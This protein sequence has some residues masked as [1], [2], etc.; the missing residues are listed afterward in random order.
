MP[1]FKI[2]DA[3][4]HYY[5][6]EDCF[7]RFASERM[8]S[9]KFVRW[10]TEADGKRKRLFVGGREANVIGNPTFNPVAAPGVYHETLKNLDVAQDRSAMA[11]GQLEQIRPAYRDKDVRLGVMDEQGVEKTLMFPTLG[12]TIEGFT[13]EDVLLQH[14]AFHAF[15]RWLE[16]DWGFAYQGRIFAAP[17]IIMRDVDLAI[18]ELEWVLKQGARLITIRPGPAYGR[19]PADPYFDPF[20]ARVEE[21]GM[22]VTY[23]AFEGP[24]LSHDG[25]RQQWAAPPRPWRKEDSLLE[26]VLANVDTSIMDTLCALVLHNLFGRFPRLR[27]ATIEMGCGWMPYLIHRLDRAGG[28]LNRK[29]SAFGGTL[30]GKP[31]EI[32]KRHV[33]VA[34]FPEE[35]VEALVGQIGAHRVLMGSDW[36]HAE[37]LPR[38]RDF[39]ECVAGLGEADKKAIM[40]DNIAGLIAA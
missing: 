39:V 5:E 20:W 37:S 30:D 18:Q 1:D 28:L 34:P 8:K 16:E 7:T 26:H 40:R 29:I 38:P 25:F 4:Q 11:Y 12:V 15:N 31:S 23:H 22:L 10:L 17:Y 14:D 19:S 36:P 33:W 27:V 35:D 9:E 32:L 6:A 21:A 2:F 13:S 3:D 24:S